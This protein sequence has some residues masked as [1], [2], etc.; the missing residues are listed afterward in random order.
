MKRRITAIRTVVS[1]IVAVALMVP[2]MAVS[3]PTAFAADGF[4]TGGPVAG[5]APTL[6]PNDHTPLAVR[7]S[8]SGLEPSSSYYVK[9]RLTLNPDPATGGGGAAHRG[10]I[11]NRQTGMWVRNRGEAWS[12]Y[13]KVNTD[14]SGNI[15]SANDANWLFF[16]FGNEGN[17]GD[18]YLNITLN[19]DGVDGASLNSN[20]PLL[21]RVIDMK[22]E[23][24]WAHNAAASGALDFKRVTF[25]SADAAS[26][27]D[28]VLAIGRTEANGIDDNSDGQ[29]DEFAENMGP[30]PLT[31][32][33]RLAALA[34]A[35]VDVYTQTTKVGDDFV[36][37]GPDEDIALG[38][39][40][41]DAPAAP[42]SLQVTVD[43]TTA[44]LTWDESLD[45]DLAG[46][47]VYRW[48][49]SSSVEFTPPHV[50]I[51]DTTDFMYEDTGLT[52]GVTYSY[53]VRTIDGSS[54]V[55]ARSNTASIAVPW[56]ETTISLEH[57]AAGV[58]F[59]RFVTG[60]STA[61]S[62]GGYVYGRWTDTAI[63]ATFMGSSIKWI[64][65]KQPFY[66][67]ADVYIDDVLVASDVDCYAPD[68]QKTLSATIWESAALV[69]GPHTIELR[70]MGNKNAAST[71]YYVVLDK[72]EVTGAAP[73][74]YGTRID[75][76]AATPGYSGTWLPYLN[77]TYFNKTYAY[78]RWTN[79]AFTVAFNGTRVSWIGP[80]TPNYG[81]AD[82]YIDDV[83]VA[84][85]DCYKA[86]LPSQ[87][88]REVVW[89]SDILAP[90]AHTLVIRPTGTKN[91][92]SADTN[93]V[94][95]AIDVME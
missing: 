16:K 84:T 64:G 87:G 60:Y 1:L 10:F 78:S 73:S 55:S 23:G 29:V 35:P 21:V 6:V 40:D 91:A 24:A 4:F 12:A 38:A 26:S 30:L 52:P 11:W 70:L 94:V 67:M 50:R 22:T 25:N 17:S 65:P 7:I 92:A 53:E 41:T 32:D 19:K 76:S 59:D 90:G 37:G 86:D 57:D 54:N 56:P 3:V 15:I 61:Y 39:A 85:V 58:T 80:R 82:V 43:G 34:D 33:W 18:Y 62:G 51:S 77:A 68:A 93:V 31:G 13:P 48:V 9:V 14:A 28:Q 89:Q 20:A 71:G 81:M 75:D 95:D 74:G 47:A 8:G 45:G 63:R 83:K 5:S 36:L 66:G 72:F 44:T 79:A 27:T 46:Y 88:W 2:M 69:D 49:D 42:T